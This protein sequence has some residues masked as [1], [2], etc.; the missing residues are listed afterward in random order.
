MKTHDSAC[1]ATVPHTGAHFVVDLLRIIDI[2]D[3]LHYHWRAYSRAFPP[4]SKFLITARDPYLVGLRYIS[5]GDRI[6]DASLTFNECIRNLYNLDHYIIDIGCRKEDRLEHVCNMA[7]FLNINPDPY[8]E[9]LELF[10]EAW[11]PVHTTEEAA[12]RGTIIEGSEINKMRYL[13]SGAL[14]QDYD[15]SVFDTAVEWYN[16]LPTNDNV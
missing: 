2:Q 1:L 10:V 16:S 13:E 9:K 11:K 12:L 6:E 8:M 5:N 4:V 15:W 7:N 3:I 14:P